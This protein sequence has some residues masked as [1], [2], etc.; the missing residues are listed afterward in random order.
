MKRA[1]CL[2]ACGSMALLLLL[3]GMKANPDWQIDSLG[4]EVKGLRMGLKIQSSF[5]QDKD[6]FEV[7]IQIVNTRSEPVTLVGRA[8]YEGELENY[9]EWIKAEVCFMTF[10]EVLPPSAQTGG[11]ERISPNPTT[12]LSPGED[13]T[14]SWTAEGRY[15]KS[16]HYYNTTPY[17][18]SDGLYGTRARISVHTDK[19][20][21]ILLHSNEQA[22]SVGGRVVLPKYGVAYVTHRDEQN[23]QVRLSLG[24]EHRTEK[25]DRFRVSG[26]F[27]SGW[28]LTVDEVHPWFSV[29][30]VE[31][32]G[33]HKEELALLPPMHSKAQLWEFGQKNNESVTVGMTRGQ[34]EKSAHH[35]GGIF[36]YHSERYILNE[37]P[38]GGPKWKVLKVKVAFKP[39]DVSDEIYNDP[40][41]FREW[42]RT[43]RKADIFSEDDIIVSISDPYWE[44]PFMD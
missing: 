11:A 32:T 3:I 37:Q 29:A 22:V 1:R 24:S 2:V 21:N 40:V 35:D 34:L 13:I 42:I 31:K 33:P 30:T 15:L 18:P 5:V 41:K 39:A 17:F 38:T 44:P 23:R 9:G 6:W 4:P 10:P 7:R 14:V 26:P 28:M 27:P 12:T 43:K 8:P 19:G 25:G 16:E 36:T 20:E